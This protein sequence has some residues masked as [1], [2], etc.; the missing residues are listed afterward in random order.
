MIVLDRPYKR[1]LLAEHIH[2]H[3]MKVILTSDAKGEAF[4]NERLAE[5]LERITV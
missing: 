3:Q 5:E 4:L 1:S 2:L